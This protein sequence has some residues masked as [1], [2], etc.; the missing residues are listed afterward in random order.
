ML[1]NRKTKVDGICENQQ[2]AESERQKRIKNLKLALSE[3]TKDVN[4]K[5]FLK[6]LKE[7]CFWSELDDNI[8]HDTIIY[9]KSRRDLWAV[10]RTLLPKKVLTQIEILEENE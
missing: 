7:A 1:N 9:K 2:K 8:N 5:F 10:I 6:F 3:S 4:V